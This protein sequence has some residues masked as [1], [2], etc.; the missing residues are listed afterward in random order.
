MLLVVVSIVPL[1]DRYDHLDCVFRNHAQ[2]LYQS[3]MLLYF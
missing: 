1:K 3:F 2:R